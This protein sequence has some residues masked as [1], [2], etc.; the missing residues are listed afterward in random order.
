MPHRLLTVAALL[1]LAPGARAA[2]PPPGL[3]RPLL[4]PSGPLWLGTLAPDTPE[5]WRA[6]RG[7]A[8][9]QVSSG[10]L[11]LWQ[12]DLA[13]EGRGADLS[14]W[15]R[16][17]DPGWTF[18]VDALPVDAPPE[19]GVVHSLH[20]ELD[21]TD[22]FPLVAR[23]TTPDGRT[24][25]ARRGPD[26][27]LR[28]LA[29]STGAEVWYEHESGRLASVV[30]SDR[31]R[32]RY[33]YDDAGLLSAVLW[34]D[35]SALHVQ[36]NASGQVT[37]LA[38]PGPLRLDLSWAPE[39]LDATDAAG[40]SW[41]VLGGGGR[42]RVIDPAGSVVET[43]WEGGRLQGWTDPRGGSVALERDAAGQLTGV[44]ASTG[45]R[46]ALAWADGALQSLTTPLGEVWTYTRDAVGRLLA[47]GSSLGTRLGLRRDAWGHLVELDWGG[48]RTLL[49]RDE[50]G[51]VSELVTP[52]GARV[53]LQRDPRGRLVRLVDGLGHAIELGGFAG[54]AP[55]TLRNRAGATWTLQHDALGRWTT[56]RGPT[57]RALQATR[58]PLGRLSALGAP[59]RR[60]SALLY[61]AAGAP[62]QLT[63]A[64]GARWGLVHDR[65]GRL[66]AVRAPD[67][68]TLALER[69]AL[70]ELTA[71]REGERAL[72][73]ARDAAG[74][75]TQAGPHRWAWGPTGRLLQV[76]GGGVALGL[77]YVGEVLSA[78]LP[79]GEASIPLV[80]DASRRV[81]A[82]GQGAARVELPRDA[83]GL[84]R[85]VLPAEGPPLQLDRDAQGRVV[86]LSLGSATWRLLRDP[87]GQL[88]RSAGPDGRALSADR[89]AAGRP[90]LL[91]LP[92]GVLVHH[93]RG[94]DRV[95]LL[96]V[97]ARGQTV[98][99][100]ELLL[101]P[102]GRVAALSEQGEL[103]RVHRDALGR[104]SAVEA[105]AGSWTR[106]PFGLSG[107]EGS[108][109]AWTP[110]GRPESAAP[111][112]GG[113]LWSLLEGPAR[114]QLG[115]EQLQSWQSAG[116]RVLLGYDALGRLTGLTRGADRW[117]VTWDVLGRP[118]RVRGPGG[119]RALR[120]GLEALLGWAEGAVETALT[121]VPGW[122]AGL[123]GGRS[124]VADERGW[125]VVW[126]EGGSL[127]ALLRRSPTGLPLDPAPVG[128]GLW[129]LLP[130][131]PQLDGLGGW[132]PATG[133]P[134]SPRATAPW[135]PWPTAAPLPPLEGAASPAWDPSPW[136][137]EGPWA[138]PLALLVALGELD[139]QLPG[140]WLAPEPAAPLGWLPALLAT[141]P[142]PLLPPQDALPLEASDPLT[143]LALRAAL[144]GGPALA[145]PAV[146][147][148]VLAPELAALSESPLLPS[149]LPAPARPDPVW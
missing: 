15:R 76:E 121:P 60:G 143:A 100:R 33:R 24:L 113:R 56:L 86:R 101:D 145:E 84:L 104:V 80:R 57:G 146:L 45:A 94:E 133:T 102:V 126:L 74:R 130:G 105:A 119:A 122:G 103:Q 127:E 14:V 97:D 140:A 128:A 66:R 58:D 87:E 67:G 52:G 11:V 21:P 92:E 123:P 63:D 20:A 71:L 13:L 54:G 69:D 95:G 75:P 147:D 77:S 3:P 142:P 55:T 114:A 29:A 6:G 78:L 79:A 16:Y 149:L 46:W 85:G 12:Q 72:T 61:G 5:A 17:Q 18:S 7:Y 19:E 26:G 91:H 40:R 132:D 64:A 144:P 73:V 47:A 131:G 93:E 37:R 28:S 2:P 120:W 83:A 65:A 35:G 98:Y 1:A 117:E 81:T 135:A 36:R 59:G 137:P 125:P 31:G 68:A 115:E 39:R 62:T 106:S 48:R 4:G 99:D 116:G 38:G 30:T 9:V 53:Q 44:A 32:V 8:V 110:S 129:E 70:G 88:V 112:P 90:T 141:P 22:P 107:P 10:E 136:L 108:Q 111:P 89:D 118:A 50:Q 49:R 27:A 134:L 82:A 41:T 23:T 109:A 139:P 42:V 138:D 124:W 148:A 25:D 43:R 96:V 51:R 34:A